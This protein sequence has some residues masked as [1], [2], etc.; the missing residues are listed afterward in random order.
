MSQMIMPLVRQK[1]PTFGLTEDDVTVLSGFRDYFARILPPVLDRLHGELGGW[2]ELA[3]LKHPQVH[4][5]RL[6]HWTRT[7]TGDWGDGFVESAQRLGQT[8]YAEGIPG[9]A[10]AV[11]HY[12]VSRALME[13]LRADVA[14][15]SPLLPPMVLSADGPALLERLTRVAEGAAWFDL[16]LLLET[17]AEAE[18]AAR[19]ATLDE[20]ANRFEAEIKGVVDGV[21]AAAQ[22]LA[23]MSDVMS[24]TAGRTNDLSE[25]VAEAAE[26]ATGNVSLVAAA[27]EEM[28]MSIREIGSQVGNTVGLVSDAVTKA[29]DTNAQVGLLSK[30]AE[31][32]GA[33]VDLISKIAAQTN[34]LAL[35]ATIEAARAGEAGRG[36]AV[37]ASEV[38][39]LAKQTAQA[40]GEIAA[41]VKSIQDRT[42][43]TVSL[44]TG[45]RDA[46]RTI[47]DV[48]L[49]INAA[50]E[51]QASAVS[52]IASNTAH[53]ATGTE[54]VT[55]NIVEVK[56]AAEETG[57]AARQVAQASGD[58]GRQAESLHQAVG[59]FIAD[60][61][62]A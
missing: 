35:N 1:M 59:R 10:V 14:A 56:V 27:T 6:A 44:I 3:A 46:V 28:G 22:Q 38:K 39:N 16:E 37:V 21:A 7:A 45:I 24:A 53:A 55:R 34:L 17:Y 25:T 43:D 8:F 47:N 40:T 49:A 26:E 18:R 15:S 41:Q 29:E 42:G 52:E 62:A 32:I 5:V 51:Q 33:V 12:T 57:T 31:G 54:H 48:S 9:Y 20:V 61:R 50:V 11:C 36:F 58:L 60:I 30:D 2:T 4:A 13:T 23:T 19:K